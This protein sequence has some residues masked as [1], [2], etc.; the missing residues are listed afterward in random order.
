M[1]IGS[2]DKSIGS[3]AADVTC[4]LLIDDQT[5]VHPLVSSPD[6]SVDV[7]RML[8]LEAAVRATKLRLPT[9]GH[10]E[11]SVQRSLV[12]VT[13]GA[14]R[15]DVISRLHEVEGTSRLDRERGI[16]EAAHVYV[17]LEMSLRGIRTIAEIATVL[18]RRI[19]PLLRRRCNTIRRSMKNN[20]VMS[21]TWN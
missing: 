18:G 3:L 15:T 12:L 4:P 14:S 6:M 9:A 11:M 13:L 20:N 19:F 17:A 5:S 8:A 2:S 21:P 1:T 10:P 7:G 16:H